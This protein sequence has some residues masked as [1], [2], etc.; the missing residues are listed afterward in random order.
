MGHCFVAYDRDKRQFVFIDADDPACAAHS[1]DG[2]HDHLLTLGFLRAKSSY[3]QLKAPGANQL[4]KHGFLCSCRVF[5]DSAGQSHLLRHSS[6][7]TL[8]KLCPFD[9]PSS[10]P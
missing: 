8:G 3:Q 10:H 6:Q 2:W 5:E 4:E 1:T 9:S 7:R